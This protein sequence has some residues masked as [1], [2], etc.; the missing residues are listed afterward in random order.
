MLEDVKQHEE[1]QRVRILEYCNM[2]E[3]VKQHEEPQRV[4]ILEYRYFSLFFL[5][6]SFAELVS[7]T[8]NY[9]PLQNKLECTEMTNCQFQTI[10]KEKSH[11]EFWCEFGKDHLSL[12]KVLV[13]FFFQTQQCC[14]L[15]G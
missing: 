15:L 10:F 6:E 2:L 7:E 13:L 4:L 1:P 11:L 3:D 5:R 9:K 8:W 14:H 12:S